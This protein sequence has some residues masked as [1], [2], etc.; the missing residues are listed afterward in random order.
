MAFAQTIFCHNY[1]IGAITCVWKILYG[2]YVKWYIPVRWVNYSNS[3]QCLYV[4]CVHT[5]VYNVHVGK[6]KYL[7]LLLTR[8][9]TSLL[10]SSIDWCAA[11][12]GAQK[13]RGSWAF[14]I[15]FLT[16]TLERTLC[17]CLIS[18]DQDVTFCLCVSHDFNNNP[19]DDF[20]NNLCKKLA[21]TRLR[22][23][24]SPPPGEWCLRHASGAHLT[25]RPL[26]RR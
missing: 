15:V 8:R 1:S 24:F 2:I 12:S 9:T 3:L 23:D 5:Q 14:S 19:T 6:C 26:W 22:R 25:S 10:W 11:T 16:Y 20:N 21:N 17:G 18:L 4:Y 7:K 13:Q